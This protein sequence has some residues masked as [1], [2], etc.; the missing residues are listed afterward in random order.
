[1]AILL[2]GDVKPADDPVKDFTEEQKGHEFGF[3]QEFLYVVQPLREFVISF[4]TDGNRWQFYKITALRQQSGH[5]IEVEMTTVFRGY[6]GWAFFLG[7]LFS[8]LDALGYV[9]M[10][11]VPDVVIQEFLGSGLSS[12]VFEVNRGD[13]KLLM[14]VF[15]QGCEAHAKAEMYALRTLAR[16]LTLDDRVPKLIENCGEHDGKWVILVSPV[17][18][19]VFPAASVGHRASGQDLCELVD[20][21]QATH[22]LGLRHDDLKP[23][24]TIHS[25]RSH[26]P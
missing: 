7:L 25:Q 3:A 14:K 13:V 12:F 26:S 16:D 6:E 23:S 2:F 11:Q 15:R 17:A 18:A 19:P 1:M 8:P 22:K 24:N 20:I 10:P 5:A 4:L 21:L 9:H